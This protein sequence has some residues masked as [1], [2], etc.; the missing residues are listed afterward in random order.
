MAKTLR[1][2]GNN[3]DGEATI[4]TLEERHTNTSGCKWERG[5]DERNLIPGFKFSYKEQY[6]MMDN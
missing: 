4:F 5:S 6:P 1:K 3:T 2:E